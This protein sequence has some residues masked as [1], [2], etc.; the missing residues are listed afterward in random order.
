MFPRVQAWRAFGLAICFL[1]APAKAGAQ[2][3]GAADK[4]RL[5]E[6]CHGPGGNSV[7]AGT[8]SIA[9]QPLTFIE[10]QLVYYREQLRNGAVMQEVVKGIKDE[11]ITAL[12]RHFS[13]Q[14]AK[15]VAATP[16][17]KALVARGREIAGRM[18]C[19][20]CHLAKF[21]GRDQ[22]PRLAGQREEY[23]YEAMIAYRDGKSSAADT[24]MI[25]V[26]YGSSDADIRALAHFLA[27]AD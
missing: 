26:F 21:E 25:E 8:P 2:S 17:D 19:G 16:A 20:Q 4:V 11:E 27:Q 7:T 12:A 10:N 3:P 24:T 6:A 18:H 9:A 13:S 15:V 22:M 5:C 1:V 23:L 14:K